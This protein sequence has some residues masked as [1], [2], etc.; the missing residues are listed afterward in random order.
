MQC[1]CLSALQAA[2]EAINEMDL[3][4]STGGPG[5][6]IHCNPDDTLQCSVR[7]SRSLCTVN[8]ELYADRPD[9]P[10]SAVCF[11]LTL[12]SRPP[13]S[14]VVLGSMLPRESASKELDSA[15]LTIVS[16]PAF[17][18][19]DPRLAYSTLTTS[20]AN[21]S[22]AATSPMPAPSSL[23]IGILLSLELEYSY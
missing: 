1:K 4:A 16:Y 19:T 6:M 17:A 3:F 11:E 7:A 9:R 23:R 22:C 21:C 18:V 15:L 12:R 5:S 10:T 20:A 14:Q 2:L 13:R 8:L